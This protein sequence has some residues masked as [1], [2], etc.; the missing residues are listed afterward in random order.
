L[1]LIGET[2]PQEIQRYLV[3]L[4]KGQQLT[5][6]VPKNSKVSMNLLFPGGRVVPNASNTKYLSQF[7]V[8]RNGVYQVDVIAPKK[9]TF[10]L[11]ITVQNPKSTPSPS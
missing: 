1:E 11:N 4:Q 8:P 3:N 9:T 2:S 10:S 7:P 5:L 6:Q